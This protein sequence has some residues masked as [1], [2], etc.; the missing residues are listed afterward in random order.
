[1]GTRGVDH[2]CL[3]LVFTRLWFVYDLFD[4]DFSSLLRGLGDFFVQ[5]NDG[6][7][8]GSDGRGAYRRSESS[9]RSAYNVYRSYRRPS[10]VCGRSKS[11]AYCDTL[12]I[13]TFPRRERRSYESRKDARD[14]PYVFGRVRG[15][16]DATSLKIH[17]ARDGRK[18]SRCRSASGRRYLFFEDVFSRRELMR[19]HY[20]KTKYCRRLKVYYKS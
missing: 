9:L 6:V 8:R 12:M 11:C 4:F 1:M 2:G 18:R 13:G 3:Q 17:S 14:T 10:G 16:L 15:D 19:V 20:R 5:F 7:D